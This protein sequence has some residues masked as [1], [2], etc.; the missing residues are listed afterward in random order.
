[1]IASAPETSFSRCRNQISAGP[2]GPCDERR[3]VLLPFLACAKKG[4]MCTIECHVLAAT[5]EFPD[6]LRRCGEGFEG[7]FLAADRVAASVRCVSSVDIHRRDTPQTLFRSAFSRG[8]ASMR[9]MTQ[10][11]IG[12]DARASRFAGPR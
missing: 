3:D 11:V 1:M 4:A 6:T 12:G 8:V 9:R 2:T 7:A 10:G 5:T